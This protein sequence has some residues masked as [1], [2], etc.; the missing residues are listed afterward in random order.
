[1][2]TILNEEYFLRK[3][4]RKVTGPD[5]NFIRNKELVPYINHKKKKETKVLKLLQDAIL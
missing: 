1:M 3:S 2:L 4:D 5:L